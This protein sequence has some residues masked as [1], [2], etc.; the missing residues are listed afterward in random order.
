MFGSFPEIPNLATFNGRHILKYFLWWLTCVPVSQIS[1]IKYLEYFLWSLRC[2][3]VCGSFSEILNLVTFKEE[4]F[5][6]IF[7]GG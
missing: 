6:N 3:P 5:S 2:A 7:F 4:L 1:K